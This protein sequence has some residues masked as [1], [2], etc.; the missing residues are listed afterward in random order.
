MN[1]VFRADASYEL[2]VGH[3]MRCLTLALVL[4]QRGVTVRFM[5]REQRGHMNDSLRDAGFEVIVLSPSRDDAAQ[6]IAAL[7][8]SRPDWLIVDHYGLGLKWESAL[9]PYVERI[10]A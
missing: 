6:C 8:G 3:I 5:C 10:L 1:F 2:G 9:R 7:A 4:R